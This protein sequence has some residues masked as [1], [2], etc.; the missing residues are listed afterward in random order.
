MRKLKVII[1]ILT[2]L[3]FVGFPQVMQ[4]M[5][6]E[7]EVEEVS[8]EKNEIWIK[9]GGKVKNIP[10]QEVIRLEVIQT[11]LAFR[12]RQGKP[13]TYEDPVDL[14]KFLDILGAE[15]NAA[16]YVVEYLRKNDTKRE[17]FLQGLDQKSL[18]AFFGY[19]IALIADTK[20]ILLP[21]A[22]NYFGDWRLEKALDGHI[23]YINAVAFSPDGNFI[24]SRSDGTQNNLILWNGRTGEKIKVLHGHRDH[25]MTLAFSPDGN[26]IVSGSYGTKN[27]LILWNCRTGKQIKVLDG[28]RDA[29]RNVVFSPDGNFIVSRSIGIKNNLILWELYPLNPRKLTPQEAGFLYR[30]YWAAQYGKKMDASVEDYEIFAELDPAIQEKIEATGVL[31]ID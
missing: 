22:L 21:T 29:I 14:D 26:F 1:T 17:A 16:K 19:L 18:K 7:E 13:I 10:K 23:D 30:A 24:V 4:S 12:K 9:A 31:H 6:V 15:K 27:N 25:I 8:E 20:L 28:H 2:L 11:Q 3:L 5:E